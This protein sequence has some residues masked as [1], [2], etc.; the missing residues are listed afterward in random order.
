MSD[1][2]KQSLKKHSSSKRIAEQLAVNPQVRQV[3]KETEEVK[4]NS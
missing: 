2:K 4:R 1:D 3:L